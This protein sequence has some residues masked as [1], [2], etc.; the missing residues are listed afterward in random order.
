MQ[1]SEVVK[2]VCRALKKTDSAAMP[3]TYLAA[4][5]NAFQRHLD[6]DHS[7]HTM[8]DFTALCTK[9]AQMY[10][11]FNQS[12]SALLRIAKVCM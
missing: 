3:E 11:G 8:Q 7:T 1:V 12:A 5:Q 10:A 2:E 4:M 6:D 9:V